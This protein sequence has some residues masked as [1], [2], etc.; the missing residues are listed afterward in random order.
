MLIRGKLVLMALA[1]IFM[2]RGPAVAAQDHAGFVKGPFKSGEEV[3]RVCLGC[4]EKQATDFMKTAHWKWKGT[5]NH[6]RGLEKSP[7]EYGKANMLNAFCTSIE[8]GADGLVHEACGKCHAGYGWTRT[9]FDFSAKERVDCLVCH[10]QKG[11][12]QRAASGCTVDMKSMEKGTMNLELAAQSVGAPTRR[13]CGYC[14]FFGGGADAVKSPGLDSTLEKAPRTQDVHM[15][16]KASGGQDMSCQDCHRTKDHKI[17][18]ASSMMAH[19]ESRVACEDCHSGAKAPHRKSKNGAIL[20]RHLPSVACQ[21]CHIPLFARAQATKMSWKWSDAG[22]DLKG[23]EE[24]DKETFDKRK[25]TFSW[26]MNVTPVYRWYNG[27]IERYMKGQ[28]VT[29][30]AVPVVMTAPVGSINDAQAKIYPYKYYTG[31]QPMDSQFKY[32]SV[33][34]QYK[35]LWADFDWNKA[36]AEGA[37]G[38]NLPYSGTYQFVNTVSYLSV[39]HEVAPREE[40]L[41]CGECHLG[42]TRLDWKALGYP[43]DP[44]RTGGRFRK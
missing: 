38:A 43:G 37:R 29:D 18:G 40:A 11:N 20:T 16:T 1:G 35:S 33:F 30:P 24:F 39:P 3:T 36:L 14:H 41:Q 27:T 6:V 2:I 42:G 9:N 32:L 34:Q 26:G 13:N 4:H 25:G 12:Y 17:A 19:F 7:T 23:D 21:T 8:G 31:D 44:M 10:A 28:V 15:G 5:P 22:K